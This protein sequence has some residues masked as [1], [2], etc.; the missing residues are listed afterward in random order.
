[1]DRFLD[2][3]AAWGH[4]DA[5]T[6]ITTQGRPK[7]MHDWLGRGRKWEKTMDLGV[8]GDAKTP[9]TFVA[10]W[11]GWWV[12]VAPADKSNLE[13]VLKLHGKNGF[14]QVMATLLWWGERVADGTPADQREWSLAVEEVADLLKQML[15]PGLIAKA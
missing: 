12:N 4:S 1:V 2:F 9:D 6:G 3:E 13:G 15:Q 7:A 8:L 5:G 14:L 10:D 11:W